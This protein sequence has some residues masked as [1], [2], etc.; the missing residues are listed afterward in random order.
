MPTIFISYSRIDSTTADQLVDALEELGID[1]FR[2]I[3]NIEWGQSIP[4][5][6]M[7][8]LEGAAAII[9][10]LSPG[11]LKSQWV[12]YEIGFATASQKRILPFLTHP[13]LD[14]PEF[15]SDLIYLTK[16]N[17]VK[18]FFQKNESWKVSPSERFADIVASYVHSGKEGEWFVNEYQN[19]YGLKR[20]AK[21]LTSGGELLR[22]S[23]QEFRGILP[24]MTQRVIP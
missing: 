10:I 2:D 23:E 8:G 6:V 22:I 20:Y 1:V 11:S 4:A 9:V 15:I 3:K 7:E 13:A 19:Q 18:S 14:V 12:S 5:K 17:D 16:I 24:N 21:R